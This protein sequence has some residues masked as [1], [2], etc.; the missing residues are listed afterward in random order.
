M[1]DIRALPMPPPF[2]EFSGDARRSGNLVIIRFSAFS[3]MGKPA[4][5]PFP[6]CFSS[7]PPFCGS[8]KRKGG[9]SV[10]RIGTVKTK[11]LLTLK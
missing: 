6:P 9:W 11:G 10:L 8:G 1:S 7:A 3:G 2:S 4:A 5:F